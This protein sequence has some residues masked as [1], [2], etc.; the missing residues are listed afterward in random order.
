MLS[1][2]NA[3]VF[4]LQAE[5]AAVFTEHDIYV[6]KGQPMHGYLDLRTCRVLAG[7]FFQ[8]EGR[9]PVTSWGKK[10]AS[11]YCQC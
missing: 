1:Q 5:L 2:G 7:R 8:S 11:I 9:K 4:E 6:K 10:H 3:L